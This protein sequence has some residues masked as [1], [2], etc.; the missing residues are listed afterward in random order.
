MGAEVFHAVGAGICS[1]LAPVALFHAL[2]FSS[3]RNMTIVIRS[4]TDKNNMWKN[5]ESG[6]IL[7][8]HV[9]AVYPFLA[10]GHQ[11]FASIVQ[12][13]WPFYSVAPFFPRLHGKTGNP[14]PPFL[15]MR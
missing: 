3:F 14:P 15:V 4:Q 1:S 9:S 8:A 10:T 5:Y 11:N 13:L 2:K 7:H 12:K 6:H